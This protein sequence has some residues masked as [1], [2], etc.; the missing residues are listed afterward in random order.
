MTFWVEYDILVIESEELNMNTNGPWVGSVR[1][2]APVP[3]SG[4]PNNRIVDSWV[5]RHLSVKIA[6]GV[7][8]LAAATAYLW[9]L[10]HYGQ[11]H[12]WI[13]QNIRWVW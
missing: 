2:A 12:E 5:D 3:P 11:C 4:T 7:V 6:I 9:M 13:E 8:I 1:Q 10:S